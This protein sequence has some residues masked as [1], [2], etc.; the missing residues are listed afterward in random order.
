[1][2]CIIEW[3]GSER[4]GPR[5]WHQPSGRFGMNMH[6]ATVFASKPEAEAERHARGLSPVTTVIVPAPERYVI[7]TVEGYARRALKHVS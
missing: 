2:R 7:G 6:A 3:P 4:Q 1:M 5:W